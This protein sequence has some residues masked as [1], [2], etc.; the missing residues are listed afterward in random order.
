MDSDDEEDEREREKE[1]EKLRDDDIEGQEDKS[2]GQDGEI[3]I[4][5]S[6]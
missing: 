2:S 5:P 6:T 1:F 4:F 3:T